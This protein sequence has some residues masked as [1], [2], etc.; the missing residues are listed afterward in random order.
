MIYWV[1]DVLEG[2]LK[3]PMTFKKACQER[4]NW[5]LFTGNPCIIVKMVVDTYGKEVK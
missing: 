2:T 3:G 4:D 1:C 5:E